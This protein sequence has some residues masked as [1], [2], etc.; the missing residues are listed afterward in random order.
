MFP[1]GKPSTLSSGEQPQ[2]EVTSPR[3]SLST[4]RLDPCTL[5]CLWELPSLSYTV[6][7]RLTR[8]GSGY[9]MVI[10]MHAHRTVVALTITVRCG[11]V[12]KFG[13]CKVFT[14]LL[15]MRFFVLFL[16]LSS[17]SVLKD[18]MARRIKET[19]I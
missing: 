16:I 7:T 11:I 9:G 12:R 5:R 4:P 2:P 1:R 13:L 15:T 14:Q 18:A 3:G 6:H 10:I 19:T 17:R 8:H